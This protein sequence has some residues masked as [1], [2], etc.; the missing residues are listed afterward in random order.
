[1]SKR[2]H[3]LKRTSVIILF[4]LLYAYFAGL[5]AVL[6]KNGNMQLLH[7]AGYIAAIQSRI[8]WGAIV[9]AV[10][11]GGLMISAFFLV[12]AR[13]R[14]D[15]VERYEPGWAISKQL[16]VLGWGVPLLA[17]LV[18]SIM[19]WDTTH[20]VDPYRAINSTVSPL[21]IQVVALR[22]KWLFLYPN[23]RIATVNMMEI[24]TGTP[25]ALQLTADAPMNSFWVPQLSGQ[26]YAMTGMVTQLHIEADQPGIYAGSSAEISG[27]DFAGMGFTVKAVSPK[28]YTTWKTATHGLPRSLDYAAYSQLAKPSGY[29]PPALYASYDRGLFQAIVMQFMAPGAN[30]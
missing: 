26:V 5:F 21:S 9:F 7:P 6:I 23:D 16:V 30:V 13:Y 12:V 18:L 25:I 27:A 14:E 28:E 4:F 29:V 20:Q 11:V 10:V 2:A 1:M 24:P 17:V 19:I 3:S 22:W 8:L 15:A